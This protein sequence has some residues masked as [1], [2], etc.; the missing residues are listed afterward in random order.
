MVGA[1]DWADAWFLQGGCDR[2]LS[3]DSGDGRAAEE[4][5]DL[6]A[7]MFAELS[8]AQTFLSTADRLYEVGVLSTVRD[9]NGSI[10][11]VAVSITKEWE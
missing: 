1:R 9:L 3:A 5:E 2:A 10:F 11:R 4:T 7:T 8:G 6:L